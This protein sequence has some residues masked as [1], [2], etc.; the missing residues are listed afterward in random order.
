VTTIASRGDDEERLESMVSP[1]L[2]KDVHDVVLRAKT[3]RPTVK[4]I[5]VGRDSV[6]D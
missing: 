2:W 6:R 4:E 1:A 5:A 3:V